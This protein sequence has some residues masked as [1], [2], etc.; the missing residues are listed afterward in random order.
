MRKILLIAHLW[1]GLVS[2]L[3]MLIV[4]TTGALYVFEEDLRDAFQW[5]LL[6]VPNESP[7]RAFI[8]PSDALA[9]M[10]RDVPHEK[11]QQIRLRTFPS[12]SPKAATILVFTKSRLIYSLNPYSGN[13]IG[14]RDMK[15]DAISVIVELH[16]ELLLGRLGFKEV[17]EQIVKWNV[18]IFFIMLLTGIVLWM[19]MNMR[20][21]SDGIKNALK[22]SFRVKWSGNAVKRHYDLHR[23]AGF[24]SFAVM[25]MVAWTGIFWVFD[26]VEDSVYAAFGVKKV[27]ESKPLSSKPLSNKQT[28]KKNISEKNALLDN[29]YS[30]AL[31]YGEPQLVSIQIPA[32]DI[33][34][35]RVL[36]R[37]PY[38]FI[39]K[40]SVL[41]FDQYTGN[42]LKSDLHENYTTPD[43]IRVSNFDLH[44]GRMFG[45]PGKILWFF[46]ALFTASLPITGAMLWWKKRQRKRLRHSTKKKIVPEQ[47]ESHTISVRNTPTP[48]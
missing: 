9:T 12:E 45:L 7:N 23:I 35:L 19:P 6:Y 37:Y 41:Y 13:I 22:H 25:L 42:L 30:E 17:G 31:R 36:V 34:A 43:K 18:L 24:Y 21:I 8:K 46:A 47:Q 44:T 14:A 40:Q 4:A 48:V 10:Q 11:V 33:D 3:I 5:N 15:S 28:P 27:F 29:A 16:T 20:L 1:L 38:R 39:R 2:G 32:K 26:S